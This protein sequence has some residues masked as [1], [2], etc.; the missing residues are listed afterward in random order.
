[1][2]LTSDETSIYESKRLDNPTG[3]LDFGSRWYDPLVG[4]FTS[5][6]DI[7]DVKHL[8]RS[9]GLNRLAFENNDPINHT[10]PSGHWSLSAI[11]GT[12]IGAALVVGAVALTIA[13]GGAA[14]PLAAAAVGALAGGGIA[15]IAYSFGI[16]TSAVASSGAATQRPSW[17]TQLLEAQQVLWVQWL[18]QHA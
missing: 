16:A 18:L 6:D 8:A 10:D 15:G 9:D 3:L 12:V 2:D 5:P 14:A 7:L 17:S 11:F 1:M 4:R 13:T